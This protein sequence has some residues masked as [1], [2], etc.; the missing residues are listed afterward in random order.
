[1]LIDES[2]APALRGLPQSELKRQTLLDTAARI[3]LESGV[4]G[5]LCVEYLLD[6]DQRLHVHALRPGLYGA[7][8]ATEMST[9]RDLAEAQ[10][11]L[12]CGEHLQASYRDRPIAGHAIEARVRTEAT[13]HNPALGPKP[14]AIRALRWPPVVP[15]AMRIEASLAPG[16]VIAPEDELLIASVVTYGQTR[17]Q[18]FLTLDRVLSE[19]TIEPIVSNLRLL[20]D[21]LAD[22][23]YRAGQYDTGFVERLLK[24]LRAPQVKEAS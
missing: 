12:S 8:G 21:I 3:A 1:V 18:A 20:R 6:G 7:V 10:I 16:V 13:P 24:E 4:I 22:E 11:R 2:P 9:G 17:H 19:T 14:D 5:A 15:G 23:S